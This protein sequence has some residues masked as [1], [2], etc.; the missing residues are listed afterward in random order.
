MGWS[1]RE[2]PA[3]SIISDNGRNDPG[4]ARRHAPATTQQEREA[5]VTERATADWAAVRRT[6][7]E[8]RSIGRVLPEAG[9]LFTE[10]SWIA[11][12]MGQ[13]GAPASVD[14]LVATLP[15]QETR[16]FLH[17]MRTVIGQTA[18]AM[19]AHD[20]FIARHCAA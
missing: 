17:H 12:L 19:P 15:V 1:V 13:A 8:R 16:R 4:A 18:V 14:P 10:D 7:E 9:S 20:Q 2:W 11:V 5:T 3:R 6:I